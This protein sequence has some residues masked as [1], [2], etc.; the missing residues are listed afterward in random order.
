MKLRISIAM[1]ILFSARLHAQDII[2][3][4]LTVPYTNVYLDG[5]RLELFD[6]EIYQWSFNGRVSFFNNQHQIGVNV[7][8]MRTDYV[9]N[10]ERRTGIGDV[11][12][13]YMI[14]VLNDTLSYT[15][16][17]IS[18]YLDYNFPTGDR[19]SGHGLGASV[20]S[21]AFFLML[22]PAPEVSALIG[23]RYAHSMSATE[24]SWSGAPSLPG[25]D[26][27]L[28]P[29]LRDLIVDIAPI[30]DF[31]KNAWIKIN[32]NFIS[33]LDEG[34]MTFN[35]EPEIGN[36]WKQKWRLSANS[37]IFIGGRKRVNS[38]IGFNCGYY[39]K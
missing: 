17:S 31:G 32:L 23:V 5:S 21:S 33:Y 22:R 14:Q 2:P 18:F 4:D 38:V 24:G 7:P 26:S 8:F 19:E 28:E 34:D 6:G 16:K 13:N 9:T 35:V 25:E 10:V 3:Y 1:L 12:L 37:R 20:L 29:K 39:F 27:I 11:R 15:K 36:I 30:L